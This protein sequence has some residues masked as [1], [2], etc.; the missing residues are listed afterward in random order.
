[1]SISNFRN[2]NTFLYIFNYK[3]VVGQINS[4]LKSVFILVDGITEPLINLRIIFGE[5]LHVLMHFCLFVFA[6]SITRLLNSNSFIIS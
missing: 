6:N 2:Y 3:I 5:R 4:K 1:M